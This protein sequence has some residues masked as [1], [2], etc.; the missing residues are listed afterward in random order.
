MKQLFHLQPVYKFRQ[1]I[2]TNLICAV[3]GS[4]PV[5]RTYTPQ[6]NCY[7]QSISFWNEQNDKGGL[8]AVASDLTHSIWSDIG[9]NGSLS[10]CT[11]FCRPIAKGMFTYHP[12]TL[13]K[14]ITSILFCVNSE[15]H[16]K[17]KIQ[18]VLSPWVTEFGS[19][20]KMHFCLNRL[21]G[22]ISVVTSFDFYT[23]L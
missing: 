14:K 19:D 2:E 4:Y 6:L 12:C 11:D 17:L 10:L 18:K 5:L 22:R 1:E 8:L 23:C 3:W 9:G 13:E 20:S 15:I 21:T 16:Y 7:S